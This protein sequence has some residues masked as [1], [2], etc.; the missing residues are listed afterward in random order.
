MMSL[1]FRY[2]KPLE[3]P[4][5]LLSLT[6]DEAARMLMLSVPSSDN[7]ESRLERSSYNGRLPHM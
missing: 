2:A 5:R 3:G 6:N 1:C 7:S 4:T